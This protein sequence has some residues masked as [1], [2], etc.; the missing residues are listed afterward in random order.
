MKFGIDM[1][2]NCPPHD[3]GASGWA[4]EDNLTRSVGTSLIS[5]LQALGHQ[6]VDCTATRASSVNDSLRQRVQKANSQNVDFFVS[7]HFNA[8][9]GSA[10]GT[11]IYAISSTAREV[12]QNVLKQI[13]QLGFK[14]RG[15]KSSGFYV[16]RNTK[17]PAILIECCFCDSE[18]DRSKFDATKMAAAIATGLTGQHPR[19]KNYKLQVTQNT[20]LKPSTEQSTSLPPE[21]LVDIQLGEYKIVD[22]SFEEGHY[23]VVWP[24]ESKGHRREHFVFAGHAK[25]VAV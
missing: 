2:H 14:D 7:I 25:V 17:M 23:S 19:P 18:I 3:T 6:V 9:N 12:A 1:G 20:V 4:Q 8:H 11:E 13:V 16:I 15:V 24:D 5:K 21:S 22:F 10:H